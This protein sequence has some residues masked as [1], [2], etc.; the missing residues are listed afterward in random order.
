VRKPQDF[1]SK[2][3]RAPRA[4]AHAMQEAMP[5]QPQPGGYGRLRGS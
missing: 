3:K 2:L 4:A 5:L 1:M